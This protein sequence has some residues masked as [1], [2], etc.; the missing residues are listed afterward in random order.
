MA[1]GQLSKTFPENWRQ[2]RYTSFCDTKWVLEAQVEKM[3]FF[4]WL[5]FEKSDGEFI[6]DEPLYGN[7]DPRVET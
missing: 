1:L 2:E 6:G 5:N 4:S 7:T 3:P